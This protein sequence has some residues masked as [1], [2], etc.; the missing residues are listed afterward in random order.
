MV[1]N[2]S[3]DTWHHG[4]HPCGVQNHDHRSAGLKAKMR[5]LF[6]LLRQ[7]DLTWAG[8]RIALSG[9]SSD[10]CNCCLSEWTVAL[11]CF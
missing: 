7:I 8:G 6:H 9:T 2:C 5:H 4:K 11:A 1:A 10:E 3:E